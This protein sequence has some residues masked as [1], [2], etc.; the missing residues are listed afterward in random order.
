MGTP[1][2]NHSSHNRAEPGGQPSDD[3]AAP[4]GSRVLSDVVAPLCAAII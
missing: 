2:S 1:K 4:E 3:I